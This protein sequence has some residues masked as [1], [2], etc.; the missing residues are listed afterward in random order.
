MLQIL[1]L[2]ALTFYYYVLEINF[3]INISNMYYYYLFLCKGADE[4]AE[5]ILCTM[6]MR[7]Y[8]PQKA[9]IPRK[10]EPYA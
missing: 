5:H 4:T 10:G 1:F 3:A 6:Y 7:C 2:Y 9:T 8:L